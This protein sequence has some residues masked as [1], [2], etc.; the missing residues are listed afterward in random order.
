MLGAYADRYLGGDVS[1]WVAWFH[2]ISDLSNVD[3]GVA[4]S[5][6]EK[7]SASAKRG[8]RLEQL[9]ERLNLCEA[10]AAVHSRKEWDAERLA[11]AR[12]FWATKERLYRKVYG[13]GL[14]RSILCAS[15]RLHR[16]GRR[17]LRSRS[18]NDPS[19][20]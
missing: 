12:A 9:R 2:E 6:F 4:R 5:Q 15:M 3:V 20:Q 13:I 19:L 1:G 8:W 7:L 14:A 18:I 17:R 10:N 11:L 16:T